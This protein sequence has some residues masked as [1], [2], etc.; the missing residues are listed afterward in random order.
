MNRAGTG[1]CPLE[2]AVSAIE[3]PQIGFEKIKET[4][5]AMKTG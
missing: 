4:L 3:N 5:L 1:L 2:Q